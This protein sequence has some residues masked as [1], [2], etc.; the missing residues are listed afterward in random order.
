MMAAQNDFLM[1]AKKMT[2]EFYSGLG[3][4]FGKLFR[5]KGFSTK[6]LGK[7]M[8]QTMSDELGRMLAERIRIAFSGTFLDPEVQKK[9]F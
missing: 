5:G 7:K 4:E 6:E 2:D 9:M 8:A 1:M 3:K